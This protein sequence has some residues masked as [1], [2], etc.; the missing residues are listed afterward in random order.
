MDFK[1]IDTTTLLIIIGMLFLIVIFTIIYFVGKISELNKKY[2][3][4]MTDSD[5]KN[6]ETM[7]LNRLD[8]IKEAKED[9]RLLNTRCDQFREQLTYCVQNVGIVR[10]NAFDDT[11]SDL[12]YAIALLDEHNNGVVLSSIYGRT[13]GRCYAKPVKNSASTYMLTDEEKQ[14]ISIGKINK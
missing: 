7:L 5:G 12:S 10:F 14:A 6:V 13:E 11:G 3:A 1:N 9:I 8:D 4:I 2:T